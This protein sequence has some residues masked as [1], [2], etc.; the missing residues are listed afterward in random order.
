MSNAENVAAW[1]QHVVNCWHLLWMGLRKTPSTN[2]RHGCTIVRRKSAWQKG[3]LGCNQWT[4]KY[5]GNCLLMVDNQLAHATKAALCRYETVSIIIITINIDFSWMQDWFKMK[6]DVCTKHRQGLKSLPFM[7]YLFDSFPCLLVIQ[8]F[9]W[10][11]D[12]VNGQVLIWSNSTLIMRLSSQV[13]G[14]EVERIR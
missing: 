2:K 10:R 13:I 1:W 12:Y 3:V 5:N 4:S 14:N 11:S 9:V 8:S 7:V 6:A